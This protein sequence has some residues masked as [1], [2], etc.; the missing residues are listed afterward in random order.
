MEWNQIRYYVCHLLAYCAS[1]DAGDDCGAI[2]GMN[3]WQGKPKYSEKTCT[4]DALS[5]TDPT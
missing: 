1:L 5:T 3:D 2:S 4:S